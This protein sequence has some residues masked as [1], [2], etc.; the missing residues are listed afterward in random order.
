MSEGYIFVLLLSCSITTGALG[1]PGLFPSHSMITISLHITTILIITHLST[2][3]TYNLGTIIAHSFMT[4]RNRPTTPI[5]GMLLCAILSD[6][7]NLQ[8]PTTTQWDKLMASILTKICGVE[9]V[10]LLASQQ[11]KAKSSELQHLTPI[12]LVNGDQKVFTFVTEAFEGSVGFAVIET[13]DDDIILA[14]AEAILLALNDDKDSKGLSVLYLAV[15]NIVELRS[16]LLCL[17]T[18]EES[19]ARAAFANGKMVS[20]GVMDLG[21]LVSRKKDFIPAIT[22]A[23]KDGWTGARKGSIKKSKSDVFDLEKEEDS[24]SIK[25]RPT[26]KHFKK[27][28]RFDAI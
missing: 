11:F 23:I 9:D 6:T 16:N 15:V 21:G 12:Q 5:A 26:S 17:G 24:H 3:T 4:N 19:L 10:Q 8:G 28:V 27:G 18:D 2:S 7:L 20:T 13:T 25:G 1:S 14:R 22:R